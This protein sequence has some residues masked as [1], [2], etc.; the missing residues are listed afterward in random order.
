[1][2][3]YKATHI[4]RSIRAACVVL[5]SVISAP[6][7]ATLFGVD[8]GN[9]NLYTVSEAT[10][11]LSLVGNTGF[12]SWADI[13]F[14]PSG[15]LYGFTT[16][17]SSNLYT[18]DPTTAA[19][20]FVGALGLPFVFEGG[21]AFNG[22]GTAYATNGDNAANPQLFTIN[23]STGAASVVGTISGG[24]RDING[25]AYRSADGQL[26]GLDRVA[27]SRTRRWWR[28]NGRGG[29]RRLPVWPSQWP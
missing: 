16:G 21:L 28:C 20:T 4:F 17:I 9:G 13:E 2:I 26:I 27:S 6:A 3:E 25:L 18:I 10:A 7:S 14:S 24:P 12:S 29:W 1:M 19:T 15:T 11:A 5:L 8:N 23:L 22:A